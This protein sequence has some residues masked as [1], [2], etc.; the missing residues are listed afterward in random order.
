MGI[1]ELP[2][3]IQQTTGDQRL[4]HRNWIHSWK[5]K[6]AAKQHNIPNVT[7]LTS[8][9]LFHDGL[10]E[11]LGRHVQLPVVLHRSKFDESSL[12]GRQLDGTDQFIV[13]LKQSVTVLH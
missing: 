4:L 11:V 9:F 7:E 10:K 6:H 5:Y 2:H 13:Q 8:G 3:D 1:A 12:P